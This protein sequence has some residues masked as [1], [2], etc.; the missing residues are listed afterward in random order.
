MFLAAAL[1]ESEHTRRAEAALHRSEAKNAAI[2][3]AL[4]DLVFVLTKDDHRYVDFYCSSEGELMVPPDQFVGKRMR[5]VFSEDFSRAFEEVFAQVVDS[6]GPRML[7]YSLPIQGEQRFYE[8]R[9]VACDDDRLLSI[10]RD[11]TERKRAEVALHDAQHAL[12]RMSRAS[13]LGELSA[14]IAHEVRQPL[15]AIGANA[16]ACLRWIEQD[17]ADS[18]QLEVALADIV[19]DVG[20]AGD[21]IKRTRELFGSGTRENAP[22]ELNATIIEVLALTRHRVERRGESIRTD[23]TQAPLWVMGDRVQLQQV[24]FNLVMNGLQ[25][26]V[27]S[28]G[29]PGPL[30]V[31]SWRADGFVHV[32][33]RDRGPGFHPGDADRI[34]EPFYTTKSDGLGIGLSISRSIIRAHG[35]TLMA[36]LNGDGG[37]T[38]EFR[39]PATPP[40]GALANARPVDAA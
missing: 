39:V 17:A 31:R 5:D 29:A 4:P 33:V 3:R 23:L 40:L 15:S 22:V 11:I 27:R 9:V 28:D 37:A 12:A 7:E 35:G 13:D 16:A 20:R 18:R 36:T 19:R 30:V 24:L 32:A 14:S 25:A 21:V 34:F 2:L 26:M 8:A 6:G 1:E 10:I 38:F